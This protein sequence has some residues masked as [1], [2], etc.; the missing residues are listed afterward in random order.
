MK[1]EV[2]TMQRI[3]LEADEELTRKEY[4]KRK[5][6][7]TKSLQKRSKITY[8]MIGIFALLIIYIMIQV[9]VY[10]R[11]NNFKYS[12]GE[13]L[14]A[15]KVYNIFFVTEGYTYDPVYS[16]S[17][18]HSNGFTEQSIYTN[19]GLSEITVTK[20][21]IYGI[22]EEGIYRLSRSTNEFEMLIENN[23]LK[24]VLKD[25]MIYFI[26]RDEKRVKS[27]DINTKEI[28]DFDVVDAYEILVD[29]NYVFVVRD[30][31]TKK[32][33]VRFDKNG[34]N[35]FEMATDANVSYMIQ[36][37][38]KIYFINKN[39]ENKIYEIGKD[40]NQ[41]Q[42]LADIVGKSDKGDI[43]E[44][45]GSKYMF[46]NQNELYFI[47]VQDGNTLWKINLETKETSKVISVA[48]EILQNVDNTIFYKINREMGVYLYNY[49]T[50]FMSLVTKRR[51]KEFYVDNY[52]EVGEVQMTSQSE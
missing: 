26:T 48:V 23:V 17:S 6:K 4:L 35:K 19:S 32:I 2:G 34:E 7:N 51:V 31:K 40:G 1:R 42:K 33:I 36:D 5:K 28:K 38:T 45:D 46:I 15:Q 52:T 20:D 16:L 43:K 3:Q 37:D 9:Y 39:D 30:D 22:K 24:Y 8:I 10:K 25:H 44:V 27:Y 29:S 47:N 41:L 50:K 14:E 49:D 18:I 21:Y 13:E 12:A 11:Y